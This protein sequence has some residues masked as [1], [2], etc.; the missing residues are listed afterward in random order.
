MKPCNECGGPRIHKRGKLCGPCWHK[1]ILARFT[2]QREALDKSFGIQASGKLLPT[3]KINRGNKGKAFCLTCGFFT[4]ENACEQCSTL[5]RCNLCGIVC[6]GDAKR[7]LYSYRTL[8]S[9]KKILEEVYI[10]AHSV[11]RVL[12][13]EGLCED[14]VDW[15][16]RIK[17]ICFICGEFFFNSLK[18]YREK[19]N[20]CAECDLDVCTRVRYSD[21]KGHLKNEA[22]DRSK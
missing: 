12:S 7:K 20:C 9:D 13:D 5:T 10:E 6:N 1:M 17:N 14:C 15:S 11:S 4:Q 21:G 22:Y 8:L 19:G 3:M 2:E 16:K 18:N